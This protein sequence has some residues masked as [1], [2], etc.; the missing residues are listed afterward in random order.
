MMNLYFICF[1]IN[2]FREAV[3]KIFFCARLVE[4]INFVFPIFIWIN[5]LILIDIMT[6][7]DAN[8]LYLIIFGHT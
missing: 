8:K 5:Y 4:F 3:V 7:V 2:C 1:L 6:C